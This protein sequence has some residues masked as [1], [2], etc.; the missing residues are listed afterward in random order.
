MR[1]QTSSLKR[2]LGSTGKARGFQASFSGRRRAYTSVR[3]NGGPPLELRWLSER[4]RIWVIARAGNL[5]RERH[6]DV[7]VILEQGLDSILRHGKVAVAPDGSVLVM[8]IAS[9]T[10]EELLRATDTVVTVGSDTMKLIGH[11]LE[12]PK[13]RCD[14]DASLKFFIRHIVQNEPIDDDDQDE[15]EPVIH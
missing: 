8:A 10:E 12:N 14:I 5:D 15:I 6:A 9:K 1:C 13:L 7:V 11:I 2:L 4:D 3:F